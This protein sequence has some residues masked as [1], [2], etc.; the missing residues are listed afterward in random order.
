MTIIRKLLLTIVVAFV[1]LGALGAMGLYQ[2][3]QA[4]QRF[5]D[6]VNNLAPSVRDLNVAT[7]AL[8]DARSATTKHALATDMAVKQAAE[9]EAG[10]ALRKISDILAVYEKSDVADDGDHKLLNADKTNLAAYQ[11]ALSHFFELSRKPGNSAEAGK[12]LT[13]GPL[14]EATTVFR[15]GLIDHIAYNIKISYDTLDANTKTYHGVMGQMGL[16]IAVVVAVLLVL[17]WT[18]Y[19][20]ISRGLNS[21]QSTLE[22]VSRSHDFTLRAP[23]HG[24]DE[25]GRTSIAFNQLLENLQG[26]L[27]SIMTGANNVAGASQDLSQTATQVSSAAGAQ[28]ESA[29]S[30]A[31]TIEQMTVSVN[32]VAERAEESRKLAENAGELAQQGSNTI[33]QTIKDIREISRAVDNAG[34]S[35]RE[36]ESYSTQ[37]NTVVGVIKDIADQTNLLA[38]NAA[39]EAARAGEMGRGFA[40][41]ADEVRKLAE[42]T[43]VSTQEISSTISAMRERSSAATEHMNAAEELVRNGVTRADNADQ[44]IAQIGQATGDTVH[45]VAEISEAIKE[46]GKATNN[47]AQR[48]EQIAQMTEEASAAAQEAA[49]NAVHLDD[50]ANQQMATLKQ[51]RL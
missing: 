16:L 18:L 23:V 38:L 34:S 21:I 49:N 19:S 50:L 20:T 5:D 32:H 35:I 45:M 41:V 39:I 46:Q 13:G 14:K 43:S 15:Q 29:S 22:T 9:A 28:S 1:A 7:Y 31:A 44:A 27:Q 24:N 11:T 40:V 48:V 8:M 17:A 33:A 25:I 37:V 51:Y 36:L 4:K 47:I 12:Y 30:M 2:L 42:R 26:S 10:T 6:V 3:E